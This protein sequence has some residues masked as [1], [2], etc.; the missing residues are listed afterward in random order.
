MTGQGDEFARE[1][2]LTVAPRLFFGNAVEF[3]HSA[4]G[5]D[6]AAVQP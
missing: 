5:A 3:T 2:P 4:I 1:A 6:A